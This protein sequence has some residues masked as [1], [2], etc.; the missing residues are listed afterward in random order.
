MVCEGEIMSIKIE[1][2]PFEKIKQGIDELAFAVKQTLGPAGKNILIDLGK[3]V[4]STRDGVTVASKITFKDKLMNM[5]ALLVREA[6]AKT[7]KQAGDGTTTATVLAQAIFARGLKELYESNKTPNSIKREIDEAVEKA[8]EQLKELATPIDNLGKLKSVATISANN[9][10]VLGSLI[11]EAVYKVGEKGSV[12]VENGLKTELTFQDGMVIERGLSDTGPIFLTDYARLTAEYENPKILVVD[13]K[14]HSIEQLMP[15]FKLMGKDS[16]MVLCASQIED[17]LLGLLAKNKQEGRLKIAVIKTPGFN[18][19]SQIEDFAKSIGARVFNQD[20]HPL[21]DAQ[22]AD[23]GTCKKI[24]IGLEQTTVIEGAGDISERVEVLKT[25]I[26]NEE[27]EVAQ[28]RMQDRL[29]RLLN[30]VATIKVSAESDTELTDKKLRIEDSVNAAKA[31]MSE[32]IVPGGGM[33]LYSLI[34][35]TSN[36]TLKFALEAP[37]KAIVANTDVDYDKIISELKPGLGFNAKTRQIA[38]L[39]LDGVIDPV[40]V[41]RTALQK[42]ASVATML[43]TTGSCIVHEVDKK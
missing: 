40:K 33:A 20:L 18:D 1:K 3:K 32:G 42:A 35:K 41:T 21:Q 29:N 12:I 34:E 16:P 15:A 23:F 30:S 7:N 11:A 24:I 6:A 25:Q 27:S 14:L 5:G 31:A 39:M 36:E 37:F 10:D 2:E 13:D 26:K 9:D 22:E 17:T 38:D 4:V 43:L 28:A 8:V 19:Y